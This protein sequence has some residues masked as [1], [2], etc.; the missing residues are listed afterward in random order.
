MRAKSDLGL[1]SEIPA[2]RGSFWAFF[3][4]GTKKA[5]LGGLNVGIWG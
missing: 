1:L 2:L 4:F 5:V 3:V